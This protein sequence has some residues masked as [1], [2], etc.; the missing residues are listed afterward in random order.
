MSSSIDFGKLATGF[1]FFEG[2]FFGV[3]MI[4]MIAMPLDF[5]SGVLGLPKEELEGSI[6]TNVQDEGALKFLTWA[7]VE[8]DNQ[9]AFVMFGA[10]VAIHTALRVSHE[11]R[12]M[13]FLAF[14]IAHAMIVMNISKALSG[15]YHIA[16]HDSSAA[17]TFG[18]AI[19]VHGAFLA[20]HSV[21]LCT[22]VFGGA[23]GGKPK[24]E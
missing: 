13:I 22:T 15:N 18:D 12:T 23:P 6:T 9:H 3:M 10:L 4:A 19:V 21:F 24:A 8:N 1:L 16:L 5:V 14:C 20:V 11:N 7:V 2:L 17:E